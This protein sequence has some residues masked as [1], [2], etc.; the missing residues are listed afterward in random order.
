ME[1]FFGKF[2]SCV[3]LFGPGPAFVFEQEV[4]QRSQLCG[5]IWQEFRVVVDETEESAKLSD[6]F[7]CRSL[8]ESSY[9][10]ICWV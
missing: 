7:G 2:E 9:F 8:L 6:I 1:S 5:K 3:V 10:V 4:V